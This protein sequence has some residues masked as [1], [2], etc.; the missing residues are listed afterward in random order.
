MRTTRE[1]LDRGRVKLT[2]E[3]SVE[4]TEVF[5]DRAAERLSRGKPISGFRPGKAPKSV[6]RKHYGDAALY[7]EAADDLVTRTLW[8]ALNQ[9]QI[10]SVGK[11]DIAV[12]TLAPGDPVVYTAIVSVMPK[13][14]L[15]DWKSIRVTPQPVV[16][17]EEDIDKVIDD[18]RNMQAA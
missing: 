8:P 4:E 1:E 3:V 2:I 12:A 18:L 5:L 11:P 9:E 10:D 6:V 16:V 7:E 14:T 17:R 13:V 15:N